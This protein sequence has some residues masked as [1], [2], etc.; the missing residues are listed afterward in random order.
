MW[1]GPRIRR[2]FP[3]RGFAFLEFRSIQE[4]SDALKGF[5]RDCRS[6]VDGV[7]VVAH[8]DKGRQDRSMIEPRGEGIVYM[9]LQESD[10]HLSCWPDVCHRRCG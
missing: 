5:D 4:A 9:R 3:R 6:K 1:R 7:R 8:F 10:Q 2:Y